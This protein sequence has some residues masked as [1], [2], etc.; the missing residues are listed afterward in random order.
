MDHIL[1]AENAEVLVGRG[2]PARLL[3]SGR[4]REQAAVLVQP[5]ARAI[6]DD[7]I[8]RLVN[9]VES[10]VRI[11][12]PDRDEAKSLAVVDMVYHRLADANLGRHDTIVAVGGG[13]TTDL[14]GFVAATWLRGIEA[15][16][17]PTTL[18]G[19]VD[20]AIGGKTGI[21]LDGKNLVGVFWLASRVL[22]D[23]DVLAALP[24]E[25]CLEGAA[26]AV[27]AGLLAD[28]I[29]L[30]EYM[31]DGIDADLGV[32]VPRAIS[33]KAGVVTGDVRE[34]GRRAILN[35]GHTVGHAVELA[36]GISHGHA[37][38]IGMVGAARV[39]KLR[40]GFD[41]ARV[42]D[43]L[44]RLGLPTS[45][46]G[47]DAGEALTLIARD[48]KRT[49]EGVRFVLL[50]DVGRPVVVPVTDEELRSALEAVGIS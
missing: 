43:V 18:L 38:S 7:V 20:A 25:L 47:V 24:V 44:E 27:K 21:N 22:V 17:V 32:I 28:P 49:V 11:D 5:G 12:V 4:R 23:L 9:E 34:L 48:K 8:A 50:E 10:V 33:V 6:A 37:V 16:L 1:I 40:F 31:H 26:E 2:L 36:A 42:V 14:G 19:A 46:E 30:D 29:I 3:P 45:I 39:S 15:V 13:A 35:F 41:E